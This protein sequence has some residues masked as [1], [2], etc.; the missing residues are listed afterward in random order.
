MV[1]NCAVA[2][3]HEQLTITIFDKQMGR[4]IISILDVK[5]CTVECRLC[6]FSSGQYGLLKYNT[7]VQHEES[8]GPRECN[9]VRPVTGVIAP[10]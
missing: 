8:L 9:I 3:K 1:A 2:A 4:S 5:F 6:L 7:L 10:Y